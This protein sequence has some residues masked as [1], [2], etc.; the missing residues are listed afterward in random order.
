[1]P[2]S[3]EGAG[4]MVLIKKPIVPHRLTAVLREVL[5]GGEVSS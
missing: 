2:W 1:M 3:G 5:D 4:D